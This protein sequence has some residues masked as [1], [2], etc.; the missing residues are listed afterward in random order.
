[1]QRWCDVT[2]CIPASGQPTRTI[3][4]GHCRKIFSSGFFV[5]QL[6]L[7]PRGMPRKK[8]EFFV[9]FMTPAKHQNYW[10]THWIFYANGIIYSVY[11]VQCMVTRPLLDK[12]TRLA[13]NKL[14]SFLGVLSQLP[15]S[16]HPFPETWV[17]DIFITDGVFSQNITIQGEAS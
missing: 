14:N 12:T 5:K 6:F 4:K 2:F 1:M 11:T 13:H 16:P 9:L 15:P 7:L 3:L 17:R 10:I 8:L